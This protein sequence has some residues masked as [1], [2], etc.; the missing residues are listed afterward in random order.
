MWVY[1]MHN[2]ARISYNEIA[3]RAVEICIAKILKNEQLKISDY[4]IMIMILPMI[5]MY[6]EDIIIV[7]KDDISNATKLSKMAISRSI[8]R[9]NDNLILDVREYANFVR[10]KIP[11]R[12][13]LIAE[14][15]KSTYKEPAADVIKLENYR[16][17]R[18]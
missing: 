17:N 6:P 12:F 2:E 13:F 3:K 4:K 7:K 11:D 10:F 9:I 15:M 8:K 1:D 18:R 14:N 16:K 5:Y